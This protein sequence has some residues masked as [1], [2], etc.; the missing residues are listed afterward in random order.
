MSG[1]MSDISFMPVTLSGVR[2]GATWT[3]VGPVWSVPPPSNLLMSG[4][5]LG[6]IGVWQSPQMPIAVARYLPRSTPPVGEVAGDGGSAGGGGTGPFSFLS[7]TALETGG[8][9][10]R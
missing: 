6:S 10:R 2:F 8:R 9:V 5:P 1:S 7:G 4:S 3:V